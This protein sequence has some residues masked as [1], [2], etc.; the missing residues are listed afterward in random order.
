MIPSAAIRAGFEGLLARINGEGLTESTIPLVVKMYD[1]L[2]SILCYGTPFS[3]IENERR[4][5]HD[6]DF[7]L[8]YTYKESIASLRLFDI[9]KARFPW[10]R[11][12]LFRK[13]WERYNTDTLYIHTYPEKEEIKKVVSQWSNPTPEASPLEEYLT[14]LSKNK[15]R[16]SFLLEAP[17][18]VFRHLLS[19]YETAG[20]SS[21]PRL[22]Y[23]DFCNLTRTFLLDNLTK[24]T[25]MDCYATLSDEER[26]ELFRVLLVDVSQDHLQKIASF[27]ENSQ[28]PAKLLGAAARPL[29]AARGSESIPPGV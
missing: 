26:I 15:I 19:E 28:I 1:D 16:F 8:H 27:F 25:F 29:L 4:A 13:R 20:R 9:P 22:V 12:T 6:L 24:E 18:H 21:S 23:E 3:G 14:R 5:Y 2:Y 11:Q 7:E 10:F 17:L